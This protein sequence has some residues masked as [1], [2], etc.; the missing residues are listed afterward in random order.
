MCTE[1]I[2]NWEFKYCLQWHVYITYSSL[3][4]I[5][6]FIVPLHKVFPFRRLASSAVLQTWVTDHTQ[7]VLKR[8]LE[9][10]KGAQHPPHRSLLSYWTRGA[11][12]Q[13]NC[14]RTIKMLIFRWC[15]STTWIKCKFSQTPIFYNQPKAL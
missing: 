11:C 8:C 2:S 10:G 12:S 4:W 9:D 6:M 1:W 15:T 7:K 3:K 5:S 13:A 14:F